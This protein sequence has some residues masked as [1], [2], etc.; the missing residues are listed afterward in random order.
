MFGKENLTSERQSFNKGGITYEEQSFNIN[1]GDVNYSSVKTVSINTFAS[2]IQTLPVKIW[3]DDEKWTTETVNN[4]SGMVEVTQ[5]DDQSLTI[6]I[7]ER[8][9]FKLYNESGQLRQLIDDDFGIVDSEEPCTAIAFYKPSPEMINKSIQ[10]SVAGINYF[11][12]DADV[13]TE[14]APNALKGVNIHGFITAPES[15]AI[16]NDRSVYSIV[17]NSSEAELKW[18]P[19]TI[20]MEFAPIAN[21]YV[22][23]ETAQALVADN[24]RLIKSFTNPN[25]YSCQVPA[26]NVQ[27][28]YL[29]CVISNL[30]AKK[31]YY[32]RI[33]PSAVEGGVEYLSFNP[34]YKYTEVFYTTGAEG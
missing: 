8:C 14:D 20:E 9:L 31:R 29:S 18:S 7:H 26:E 28:G 30:S 25:I 34:L 16:E 21:Y 4:L 23:V 13:N 27:D 10:G 2:K 5:T 19:F 1:L 22:F 12:Y 24:G 3:D 11:G 17:T 6:Y 33:V 32:A 15:Y